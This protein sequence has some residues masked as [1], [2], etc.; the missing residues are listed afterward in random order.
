[1]TSIQ[2]VA[3]EK[4]TYVVHTTSKRRSRITYD[5]LVNGVP[6]GII[7]PCAS[8]GSVPADVEYVVWWKLSS[9]PVRVQDMKFLCSV[10]DLLSAKRRAAYHI[11]STLQAAQELLSPYVEVAVFDEKLGRP[12]LKLDCPVLLSEGD[13]L[14]VQVRK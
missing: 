1:M 6:T 14:F 12:K 13:R 9:R 11:R 10:K 2:F 3:P 4:P 8:H 7:W 5:I